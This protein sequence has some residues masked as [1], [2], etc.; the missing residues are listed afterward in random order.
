[1]NRG[2]GHKHTGQPFTRRDRSG[3]TLV[4][5]LIA[6]S[7][8]AV[9]MTA[10]F[11]LFSSG[12]KLRKITRDRMAF[13][14]DARLL[15]TALKD[16]LAN[17]VP[18]GPPPLVTDDS[19][20][21]WRVARESGKEIGGLSEA[22]MVTYQWSGSSYQ[23][24]LLVRLATPIAVDPADSALVHE[25]FLRWARSADVT[26]EIE[27]IIHRQGDGK[28]FGKVAV[29]NDLGGSWVA[30]PRIR[31]FSFEIP[32][33]ITDITA[34]DINSR[35]VLRLRPESVTAVVHGPS[36]LK[37][38]AWK[39]EDGLGIEGAFWIPT[40][41]ARPVRMVQEDQEEDTS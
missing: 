13:D 19:I 33:D 30:Y 25:E 21:L 1:M 10:V 36:W 39:M 32:E 8:L 5:V 27:G 37:Q 35:L 16:D 22:R 11:T 23:D 6:L 29:L 14:R 3:F 28:K 34:S 20:V 38:N 4:E 18:S 17:L 40:G 24:S 41:M 2:Y 9:T 31:G 7:V 26:E 15:M 12:L